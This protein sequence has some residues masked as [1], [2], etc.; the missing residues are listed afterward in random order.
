MALMT[1]V[2]MAIALSACRDTFYDPS[3]EINPD[4]ADGMAFS[5]FVTE[6][7]DLIYNYGQTRCSGSPD[8]TTVAHRRDSILIAANKFT[9][10]QFEGD[11]HYGLQLHRMPLPLVGIH[12]KTVTSPNSQTSTLTRA[13][14]SEI[15]P[16]GENPLSFHDSLT[17][18]GYTSETYT[19][20]NNTT[21]ST[22]FDQTILKKLR[23]WRSS[24]HWPYGGGTMKFFAVSP[25]MESMDIKVENTPGYNVAPQF[26]YTVPDNPA[27]QRDL[28]YGESSV[29]TIDNG[30][31]NS[32]TWSRED[33]LGEDNK[34]VSLSFQHILTAVR[35]A[36]GSIPTNVT[37]KSIT[38][39]HIKEKGTYTPGTGWLDVTSSA[40][41][42]ATYTVETNWTST[43]Y[44]PSE[45]TY[46]K[47]KDNQ[48]FVLFLMPHTLS[49]V[50]SNAP[51]IQVELE[52]TP[53]VMTEYGNFATPQTLSSTT[54]T[55]T[56]TASLTGDV[57]NPGYTVTYKLT[58][59]QLK[60]GYYLLASNADPLEHDKTTTRRGTFNV[61]SF[62]NYI[63]YENSATGE[64]VNQDSHPVNWYIEA[65]AKQ[66]NRPAS[67][68]SSDWIVYSSD[69]TAKPEWL[70]LSADVLTSTGTT[71]GNVN[72]EFSISQQSATVHNHAT[73][74]NEN[75]QTQASG[76]DLAN[77]QPYGDVSLGTYSTS[78]CYIVNRK[79]TF[80]FPL[81][82]G[83][84]VKNIDGF[85]DHN[86]HRI[87]HIWIKDQLTKNEAPAN[88]YYNNVEIE[89]ADG[90]TKTI[91]NY[92][93]TEKSDPDVQAVVLWQDVSGLIEIRNTILNKKSLT[94]DGNGLIQFEVK[95]ATPGNAVIA[96]QVRKKIEHKKRTITSSEGVEPVEYSEWVID[97]DYGSD[98]ITKGDW[99]TAWTWH[100]WMTD[101]IYPNYNASTTNAYYLTNSSDNS[102]RMVTLKDASGN[103]VA[104]ILPVNLGW[105]PD[106]LDF[107][108]Y[109]PRY[110]WLKLKQVGSD[111]T[112]VIRIMQHARQD[113]ITGTSTIYQWGRPTALPMLYK[114]DGT[115]RTIYGPTGST[116]ISD[117]FTVMESNETKYGIAN[118]KCFMRNTAGTSWGDLA[119]S[120]T[121]LWGS[122]QGNANGSISNKT[123]YDPCPA[124]FCVPQTTIFTGF[125]LTGA[126][127]NEKGS[128]LNIWK[129][130]KV[131]AWDNT[132]V[133]SAWPKK[134]GYFYMQAHSDSIP[135]ADRYTPIFYMPATG[136]WKVDGAAESQMNAAGNGPYQ[137]QDDKDNDANDFGVYWTSKQPD[138]S[139]GTLAKGYV[140]WIRPQKGSSDNY[141]GTF[142][143]HE[144]RGQTETGTHNWNYS[145]VAYPNT[146]MPIRPTGDLPATATPASA[147]ASAD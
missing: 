75:S 118:P 87:N 68:E 34:Y 104:K 111:N 2:V 52:E 6:Q 121:N 19:T 71:G 77:K 130:V 76:V 44:A 73:I 59:G 128:N 79:G 27:E 22:I 31:T 119:T 126:A 122:S 142:F 55:H 78:N 63:S 138:A 131:E 129:N 83:N 98:G 86:G 141:T 102:T 54:K 145:N 89:A 56:I 21:T 116:D 43:T 29:I 7:A 85:P 4:N 65:F 47:D 93:W 70:N 123:V 39:Y 99:E 66:E 46:I 110:V 53:Y 107:R 140:L 37:I 88:T 64:I 25:A 137:K 109:Q 60:D 133:V 82:Y 127:F 117:Q 35:F 18:W 97:T 28:L 69:N 114:T 80:T 20:V 17:I 38:L 13:P 92:D 146:A 15:V 81:I 61:H 100:I 112:A 72:F 5:L 144:Y 42:G 134:G 58:I 103:N 115:I 91:S 84:Q 132:N 11:N 136:Y 101:E 62:E 105:V 51:Q 143:N 36:Q 48:D 124:G 24:A 96:L 45:N 33:N 9:A 95:Q 106:E 113:D 125:S 10:R 30:P 139:D 50:G 135:D 108:V 8:S 12:P 40:T 67:L 120:N 3:D 74:L 94:E 41:N 26:T 90:L 16:A 49:G 23:N 147:P 57:W 14:L 32:S 1:A